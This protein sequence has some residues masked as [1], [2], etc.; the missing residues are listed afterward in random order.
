MSA[1]HPYPVGWFVVAFSDELGCDAPRPLRY[2]GRDLVLFRDT[3]GAPALLDA[4]CPHLGAHLGVGGTIVDGTVQCPFHAWRFDAAG[5]CVAVPYASRVPKTARIRSYPTCEK[6]G[7]VF[8]FYA[9]DDRAPSYA[10]PE[11]EAWAAPGWTG[12]LGETMRIRTHPREIV[13]NVV[14]RAHFPI[15]HQNRIDTFENEFVDERAIQRASGG[16]VPGGPHT[17]S[18]Y[19]Y[20]SEAI[21]YGPG[22]QIT[23]MHHMVETVLVNAHTRIDEETLD[24]RFGVMT[25]IDADERRAK[26]IAEAYVADI[27]SGFAKDVAIWE[28]KAYRDKPMLCDGDGPIGALRTWYAQFYV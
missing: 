26:R 22:Y 15:V 25:R 16:G 13:E 21:Y 4:H 12:W 27:R 14:D 24:L 28:H 1:R 11:L 3:S 2:F 6:N 5:A 8:A 7:L 18:N 19:D 20:R 9:P 10:I 17:S 23:W